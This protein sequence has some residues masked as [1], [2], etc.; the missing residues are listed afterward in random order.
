VGQL[1]VKEIHPCAVHLCNKHIHMSLTAKLTVQNWSETACVESIL[2][3]LLMHT[4]DHS[5]ALLYMCAI[6][7]YLQDRPA[8]RGPGEISTFECTD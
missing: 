1:P 6:C 2:L 7:L 3:S 5:V 4:L 8:A